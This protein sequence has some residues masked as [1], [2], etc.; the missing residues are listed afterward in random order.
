MRIVPILIIFV[1]MA[2]L[3]SFVYL[4]HILKRKNEI[5]S[6]VI[7]MFALPTLSILAFVLLL[8]ATHLGYNI[9]IIT[10]II[11][12]MLLTM[13]PQNV[14]A[15]F[16]AINDIIHVFTKRSYKWLHYVGLVSAIIV[17]VGIIMGMVNRHNLRVREV[18]I[19]SKNLPKEFEGMRIAHIT[20][21]HLGNLTPRDNYLK[22]IVTKLNQI[23]PDMLICPGDMINIS[24]KEV[25]GLDGLFAS[26]NAPL[27]RYAVMGN[28]DYGDYKKWKSKEAKE[29]N[30]MSAY[31][32]Y[33]RVG[34]VLLNDSAVQITDNKGQSIDNTTH[35]TLN[36]Q[37]STISVIGVENWG[38][39]PFPRYG[40]LAKATKGFEPAQ[41]NILLSHDPS[42]W[43]EEVVK[44]EYKYI[45]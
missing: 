2:F 41:F 42:H 5:T 35:S 13:L 26:V 15:I 12:T 20:D 33:G 37:L 10:W 34:F 31:E 14:Y 19:Y 9:K 27:G 22:K 45:D 44:Q 40:D 8:L 24:A 3:P 7:A 39:P 1:I 29:A 23:E 30:L 11:W 17:T 28:H 6:S 36:S 43:R 21:L 16:Y 25:E 32:A 4:R 38:K 18:T